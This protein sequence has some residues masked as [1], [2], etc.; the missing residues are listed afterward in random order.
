MSIQVQDQNFQKRKDQIYESQTLFSLLQVKVQTIGAA[1]KQISNSYDI[2]KDSI[3]SIYQID[4]KKRFEQSV[5]QIED[6]IDNLSEVHTQLIDK[7]AIIPRHLTG[8]NN[9]IQELQSTEKQHA[10]QKKKY[11]HY[12]VKLEKLRSQKNQKILTQQNISKKESQRL[13]R[14]E[15][16]YEKARSAYS[17]NLSQQYN[18]MRKII[19]TRFQYI[20]PFI[21]EF[22][23][24]I[25]E[26][27]NRGGSKLK[28]LEN[29]VLFSEESEV[30]QQPQSSQQE[31]EEVKKLKNELDQMKLQ[32]EI[33]R[34]KM[35]LQEQTLA[36]QR[37][38]QEIL[39]SKKE[40]EYIKS[41]ILA[42]QQQKQI[43]QNQS[44][45]NE[46]FNY[47]QNQ[48]KYQNNNYN[49]NNQELGNQ[50]PDI[51]PANINLNSRQNS[52]NKNEYQ[53]NF[54]KNNNQSNQNEDWASSWN[55]NKNTNNQNQNQN[56]NNYS[57]YNT[58]SHFQPQQNQNTN[59]G[60]ILDEL[61]ESS[62]LDLSTVRC[63]W[64][65]NL[66]SQAIFK[67][68][69]KKYQQETLFGFRL[70][71]NKIY[72]EFYTNSKIQYDNWKSKLLNKV[73]QTSFHEDF[74]VTKMIG[75]GSFAKVYLATKNSNQTQYAIKAF[76]KEFMLGQHKGVESILNEIEI[77]R[78]VDN[79]FL[80]K[81]YEVYET[82][83]S[84]Y[85]VVDILQG[86]ELLSNVKRGTKFSIENTQIIMKNLLTALSHLHQQGI[87]H[88][89]LKPE[90]ILIRS[91][92]KFDIVI[93]D[94]GLATTYE[95][96]DNIIFKRCGT[97]GFVAPEILIFDEKTEFYDCKC[98]IY[99]A[100]VIM[101]I[102]L[103]GEQPFQG[104]DYK[105]ILSANKKS[106]INYE[107]VQFK[108]IHPYAV[109]LLSRIMNP[110][111]QFRYTAKEALNHRFF[112]I[113][114]Q[115]PQNQVMEAKQQLI[116][117]LEYFKNKNSQNSPKISQNQ[118]QNNNQNQQLSQEQF[119]SL[120]FK[121]I[122]KPA[123][124]GNINTYGSLKIN[125]N[126]IFDSKLSITRHL[127]K[128][129]SQISNQKSRF[130][131]NNDGIQSI[132][133]SNQNQKKTQR[134][135]KNLHKLAIKNSYYQTKTLQSKQSKE[136][137]DKSGNFSNQENNFQ[138]NE[139]LN[140]NQNQNK[141]QEE[142]ED[143]DEDY[144]I[145]EEDS[146]N[147]IEQQMQKMN[148][149]NYIN[150]GKN[151]LGQ[152]DRINKTQSFNPSPKNKYDIQEQNRNE[153]AE[154]NKPVDKIWPRIRG[155]SQQIRPISDS[156]QEIEESQYS[157]QST[158]GK[159]RSKFGN[160]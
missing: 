127:S 4:G 32:Q 1:M 36:M 66:D 144:E 121:T 26:F 37:H 89:D 136:I 157:Q 14:N 145:S 21:I 46:D 35:E 152:I 6:V 137:H 69:N 25:E 138:G 108:D 81:L 102:L 159:Q 44:Y 5:S 118:N 16:K 124:N 15:E 146:N 115:E 80:L 31:D 57:V 22:F 139:D 73:L 110:I 62:F 59:W 129:D 8:W 56:Q 88:R 82:T 91:K 86:G 77:M 30:Y 52:S 98:D 76:N 10:T 38:E 55:I 133:E 122:S 155:F 158:V 23:T 104:N 24:V 58:Q 130:N 47:S 49:N 109:D 71:I 33:Q 20:N 140:Q 97:P 90:N 68:G 153:M 29:I 134:M 42:S 53:N 87:M 7:F 79:Q 125:S 64:L 51:Q 3:V 93:A 19:N 54:T 111:P 40:Q 149:E 117:N 83:N 78:N 43:S 96:T 126:G 85:F 9:Q 113:Q 150:I 143:D 2:I 11:D 28:P 95:N 107:G 101:Y 39:D 114:D 27:Y 94:F 12:A 106:Q 141:N 61:N 135:S 116:K 75:K 13:S 147:S 151:K 112:Q 34:K 72:S 70:I 74:Q 142:E 120:A 50:I 99:S 100:G 48:N 60:N 131:E 67:C 103:T 160:Q 148:F 17:E 45:N 18:N 105:Q 84:I 119:G 128:Q 123:L 132:Q 154:K 156:E 63:Q 41:Q 92:G 65:E